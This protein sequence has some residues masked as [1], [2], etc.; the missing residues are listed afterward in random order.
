MRSG[1]SQGFAIASALLLIACQRAEP[2]TAQKAEQ[3]LRAYSFSRVPVYAELPQKVWWDEQHPKDDFD[4]KS[5]RTL[6][7]LARAGYLT[8]DE[9]H[10]NH[11]SIY[12]GKITEKGFRIIGTSPSLRGPAFRGLICYKKYDGIRNFQRH[13]NEPTVGRAELIW[14]YDDPTEL[15]PLFETK[16]NKPLKKPFVSLVSFYFKD[17]E[18]KFDVTVPKAE[19]E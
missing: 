15:Y 13:P 16:I 6:N 5:V 9:K 19:L 18:W 10:D 7:N 12:I 4:E 2:L 14:H 11:G 8:V 1:S 3:I 17:H